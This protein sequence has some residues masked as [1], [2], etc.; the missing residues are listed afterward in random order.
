MHWFIW[1]LI[2]LTAGNIGLCVAKIN[3]F[4]TKPDNGWI[5]LL[6]NALLLAGII[7]YLT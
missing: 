2:I 1:L 5:G 6:L 7:A 3:G 4:R